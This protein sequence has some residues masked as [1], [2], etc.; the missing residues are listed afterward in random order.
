MEA[1]NLTVILNAAGEIVATAFEHDLRIP[2]EDAQTRLL[3][4]RP[5]HSVHEISMPPGSR[6][7]AWHE[8]HARVQQHPLIAALR[9]RCQEEA[10]RRPH[11]RSQAPQLAADEEA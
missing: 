2:A 6:Q 1:D 7:L 4:P 10:R 11:S 8:L 5:G 9:A 3:L